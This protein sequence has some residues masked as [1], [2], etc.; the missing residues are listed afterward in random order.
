M[1]TWQKKGANCQLEAVRLWYGKDE[2]A[3]SDWKAPGALA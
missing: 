1:G 3:F 2:M